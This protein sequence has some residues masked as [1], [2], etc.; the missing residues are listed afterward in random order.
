MWLTT[1]DT[2]LSLRDPVDS[3]W[4]LPSLAWLARVGSTAYWLANALRDALNP[5]GGFAMEAFAG[6]ATRDIGALRIEAQDSLLWML[7]VGFANEG[8]GPQPAYAFVSNAQRGPEGFVH[9]AFRHDAFGPND[10]NPAASYA[11]SMGAVPL[12]R[13]RIDAL[14]ALEG[15][16]VTGCVPS[17][18][19]PRS[20]SA[21]SYLH[22]AVETH[23][24]TS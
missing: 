19:R 21:R 12:P 4:P 1:T 18:H 8:H 16:L 15:T 3:E 23:R 5:D 17:G 9:G 7:F 24:S 22:D 6:R 13:Q 2:N 10:D 11:M 20:R 14:K